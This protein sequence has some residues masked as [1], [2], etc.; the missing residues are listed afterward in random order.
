MTTNSPE[1]VWSFAITD[2]SPR[3][4]RF[5]PSVLSE[6]ILSLLNAN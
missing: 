2:N 3:H 6:L 5:R 4:T 1:T